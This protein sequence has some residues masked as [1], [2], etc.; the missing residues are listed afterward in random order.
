MPDNTIKMGVDILKYDIIHSITLLKSEDV[1]LRLKAILTELAQEEARFSPLFKPT[2]KKLT[3]KNL[4]KEQN[5]KGVNRS[6]LDDAI[7]HIDIQEPI[8]TL[9]AQTTP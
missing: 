3:I 7:R 5:Y 9:L 4:K 2:K 1:L 8:E 6:I